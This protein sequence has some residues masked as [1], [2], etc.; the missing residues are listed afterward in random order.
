ML[1]KLLASQLRINM[2]TGVA[3]HGVN[4]VILAVAY[5]VYLHYLGYETYGLW[6]ALGVVLAFARLSDLG[7]TQAVTKLVAEEHGR[8]NTQ[9][10]QRYVATAI[11][12]LWIVSGITLAVILVFK[13]QIISTF[14][15]Y[16]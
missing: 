4:I 10:V 2:V 8:G 12:I 3:T 14:K 16:K 9:V 13:A 6:L 11:M 15:C 5:P 7:M 1:K